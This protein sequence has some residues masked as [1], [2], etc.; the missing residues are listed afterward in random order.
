L[1]TKQSSKRW[2]QHPME[3]LC[4]GNDRSPNHAL[5]RTPAIALRLQFTRRA[6]RVAELGSLG[7][8]GACVDILVITLRRSCF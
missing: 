8:L 6:G 3:N 5:Q 1:T 2:V 7:R 4:A